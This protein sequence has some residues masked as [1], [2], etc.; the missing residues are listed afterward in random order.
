LEASDDERTSRAPPSRYRGHFLP[1]GAATLGLHADWRQRIYR[2]PRSSRAPLSRQVAARRARGEARSL[3]PCRL[4]GVAA[5]AELAHL[6]TP[7]LPAFSKARL[8]MPVLLM[9]NYNYRAMTCGRDGRRDHYCGA[10]LHRATRPVPFPY[11]PGRRVPTSPS[12]QPG[13]TRRARLPRPGKQAAGPSPRIG[14][15]GMTTRFSRRMR[16]G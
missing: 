7:G 6:A 15:P 13:L 1:R 3:K 14:G 5:L 16:P 10:A 12:G 9:K 8:K 4:T 11:R 2:W